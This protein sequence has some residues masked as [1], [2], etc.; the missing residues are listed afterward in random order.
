GVE[1][2]PTSVLEKPPSAELRPDQKDQDSLPPYEVLDKLIEQ[3]VDFDMT[4]AEMISLGA[5]PELA[6]RVARL[7]DLSEYKRR[8]NPPGVRVSEK[9][10]GKDRR[11][12]ITNGFRTDSL[13]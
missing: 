13:K 8:Q 11:M 1:L 10:F 4:S 6:L 12:P 5:D 3:Y 2:I 7:I 9:A